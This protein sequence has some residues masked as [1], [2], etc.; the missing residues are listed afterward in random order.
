M[1]Q[2]LL[3]EQIFAVNC[4]EDGQT[5]SNYTRFLGRGVRSGLLNSWERFV[6]WQN[7]IKKR[8]EIKEKRVLR[9]ECTEGKKP[10]AKS[11]WSD[12]RI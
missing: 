12:Y 2:L 10:T 9:K 11:K 4:K 3:N 5:G 8:G 1:S 7:D 6:D